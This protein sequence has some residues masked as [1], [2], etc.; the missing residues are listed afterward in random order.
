MNKHETLRA[1]EWSRRFA[2]QA[3][4][5]QQITPLDI[6]EI[7]EQFREDKTFKKADAK[8]FECLLHSGAEHIEEI[9]EKI[10]AITEYDFYLI[11]LIERSILLNAAC[12]I[13]FISE[14]DKAVAITEAV[15]LSKKFGTKEGYR[16]INGVLDKL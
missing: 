12:E 14:I 9:I 2:M 11:D 3:V 1:R 10:S 15:R 13:L 16:F 4:Y 5:Q 7:I 8:Y 6:D